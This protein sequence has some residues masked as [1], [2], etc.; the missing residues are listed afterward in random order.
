M[1]LTIV[2]WNTAGRNGLA[3]I[4]LHD[5]REGDII[6]IQEPCF[7]KQTKTVYC[8]AQARYQRVYSEGRAAL[9]INKRH[10][11][12]N[13]EAEAGLDW[14]REILHGITIWSIYSPIPS[15]QPTWVSPLQR[16]AGDDCR[17]V[18]ESVT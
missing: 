10:P 4:A 5:R 12:Q 17:T 9:Y 8:L 2:Y 15:S 14:C 6:P 3:S 18:R 11:P 7:N 16:L 13:W 1:K